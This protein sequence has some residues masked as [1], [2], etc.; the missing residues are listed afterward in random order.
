MDLLFR[1]LQDDTRR[2]ILA[3]LKKRDMTAGEIAAA[4]AMSKPSISYHLDLLKQARLVSSRKEG[5]FVRYT[6]E[7]TVLD[8]ALGWILGLIQ[9]P[10]NK[11][12]HE[13]P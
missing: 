8:E 2:A 7:T 13:L 9:K 11:A 6:L 1:A 4:F 10:K 3:M 12:N 5:Q